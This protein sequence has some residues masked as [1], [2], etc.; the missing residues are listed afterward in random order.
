MI[1]GKTYHIQISEEQECSLMNYLLSKNR[2]KCLAD[3]TVSDRNNSPAEV[4]KSGNLNSQVLVDKETVGISKNRTTEKIASSSQMRNNNSG[5]PTNEPPCINE[6]GRVGYS[7]SPRRMLQRGSLESFADHNS[8]GPLQ[9]PKTSLDLNKSIPENNCY[10]AQAQNSVVGP[11]SQINLEHFS[12]NDPVNSKCSKSVTQSTST[13]SRMARKNTSKGKAR[14]SAA[15][16]SHSSNEEEITSEAMK[17]WEVGCK[18]G[19]VS[20][21]SADNIR[22]SIEALIRKDG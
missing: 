8:F 9:R 3:M 6:Q 2:F 11:T 1:D 17:T 7:H 13:Q 12:S 21:I 5:G 14:L 19:M 18:L 15:S 4:E 22:G 20:E 16:A 10:E